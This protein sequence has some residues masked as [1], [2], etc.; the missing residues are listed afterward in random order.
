MGSSWAG[1]LGT[2]T[3]ND[4]YYD[5]NGTEFTIGR[6]PIQIV[7]SG[8]VSASAGGNHSLFVKTDGALWGMGYNSSGQLGDGS[9]T[10]RLTVVQVLPS[11]VSSVFSGG[12]HSLIL[13]GD[14]SLWSMGNNVYGQLG[15]GSVTN[16]NQPVSIVSSG[17]TLVAA[18]NEHSIYTVSYTH[19]TLPTKA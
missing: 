13:K 14:S 8:V 16:R 17:V 19:L 1:A 15:D 11:G 6:T 18:G 4:V 9:T 12:N 3:A 10:N 2:G 5:E 7:T